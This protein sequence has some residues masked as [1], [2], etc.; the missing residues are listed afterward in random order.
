MKTI[1]KLY[2]GEANITTESKKDFIRRTEGAGY[3]AKGKALNLLDT[4]IIGT[5]FSLYS[6]NK[7]DLKFNN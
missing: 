6:Y 5:D 1:Y 3:I 4:G 2:K 7:N